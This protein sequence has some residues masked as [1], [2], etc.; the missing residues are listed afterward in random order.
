MCRDPKI[1]FGVR[2]AAQSWASGGLFYTF[3]LSAKDI[4]MKTLT[5]VALQKTALRRST[6][7]G[8]AQCDAP[9]S[10]HRSLLMFFNCCR[11]YRCYPSEMGAGSKF[12]EPDDEPVQP[13]DRGNH[14]PR[15]CLLGCPLLHSVMLKW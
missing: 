4:M 14:W 2:Y 11:Y 12:W 9:V 1:N 6:Q 13:V 8:A 10:F 7:Q 3:K 15:A 5:T